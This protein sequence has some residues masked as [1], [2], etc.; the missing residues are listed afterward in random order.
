MACEAYYEMGEFCKYSAAVVSRNDFETG[1]RT[2]RRLAT[3]TPIRAIQ[4]HVAKVDMSS[5]VR[6]GII[7][8][9]D[10][11]KASLETELEKFRI[12]AF[13]TQIKLNRSFPSG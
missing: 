2:L 1:I 3:E 12:L 7:K 5:T 4:E 10:E 9:A 6:D 8:L 13:K 11:K